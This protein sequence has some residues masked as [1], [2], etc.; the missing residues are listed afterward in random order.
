M[1]PPAAEGRGAFLTGAFPTKNPS[2]PYI[3]FDLVFR[4]LIADGGIF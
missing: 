1:G 3:F 4:H 2:R